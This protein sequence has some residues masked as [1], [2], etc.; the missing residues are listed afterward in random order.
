M[1]KLFRVLAVVL[2]QVI[3]IALSMFTD[4]LKKDGKENLAYIID[5]TIGM[6]LLVGLITVMIIGKI[7]GFL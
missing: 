2:G 7:K 1:S 6:V 3:G 4:S 5:I